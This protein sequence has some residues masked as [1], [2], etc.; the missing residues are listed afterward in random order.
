MRRT[1]VF[2][3]IFTGMLTSILLIFAP[4]CPANAASATTK[5]KTYMSDSAITTELKAKFLAEK[6]LDSMDIKVKTTNGIVTLRGQVEKEHQSG[7]AER[8]ARAAKGVRGVNNK[9]SVMP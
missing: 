1:H 8:I 9:I 4:I 2:C 6:G 7:L 5:A 3:L